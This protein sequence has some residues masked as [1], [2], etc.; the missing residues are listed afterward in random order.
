MTNDMYKSK[1]DQRKFSK[2]MKL[3]IRLLSIT[4]CSGQFDCN[5][6][7]GCPSAQIP[8]ALPRSLS[9]S[10]TISTASSDEDFREL[11][12]AAS[13]RTRGS[14]NLDLVA[15]KTQ[16]PRLSPKAGTGSNVMARSQSVRIGRIDEDKPCEFDEEEMI[17]VKGDV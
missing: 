14:T 4:K 5:A 15:G 7:M 8:S 3:P 17:N 6:M 9:A 1:K 2:L 13:A 12:R 16:Q 10:S 11:E